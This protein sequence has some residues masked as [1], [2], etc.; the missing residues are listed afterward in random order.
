MYPSILVCLYSGFSLELLISL[1]PCPD[2][3]HFISHSTA[4][5][6]VCSVC[7]L[8]GWAPQALRGPLTLPSSPRT[9]FPWP[10]ICLPATQAEQYW[11]WN[12]QADK[13]ESSW[14]ENFT[15]QERGKYLKNI[16]GKVFAKSSASSD[17][18]IST[19]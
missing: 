10:L 6:Q 8:P 19:I 1:I 7:L 14:K 15:H 17:V 4:S 16:C 3:S 9:V 12:W 18:E 2:C 13:K 5:L 11:T